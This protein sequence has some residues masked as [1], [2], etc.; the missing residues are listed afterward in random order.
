M[1]RSTFVV[2]SLLF[3]LAACSSGGG[4]ESTSTTAPTTTTAPAPPTF[5]LT[6]LPDAE[7]V[8][9]RPAMTVKVDNADFEGARP[10]TALDQADIVYE[11]LAEGG[12]TRFAAVFQSQVPETVG[13]IRSV[14]GMDP[15]LVTSLGGIVVFSGGTEENVEK[16]A[17]APVN[18]IDENNAG[19]AFFRNDNP[20]RE[21]SLFGRGQALFDFGGEPVP[22]APQFSY[23]PAGTAMVGEPVSAVTVGF[24][25]GGLSGNYA[26]TYT[27][28]AA[29][30]TW[31]R[32]IAGIPFV[33]ADGTQIAPTNVIV[34]MTY[35]PA[36]AEGILAG[37]GDVFVFTQGQLIRGR[38]SRQSIDQPFQ[39]VDA[40]GQPILLTPGTTWVEL[41]P[42]GRPVDV[43]PAALA[44]P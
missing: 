26:S 9:T 20:V 31:K 33:T 5:P 42:S 24:E 14:R 43:V 39:Y 21:H 32:D 11:E 19:D 17:S 2:G 4:D 30:S 7:G 27:W 25:S 41:L 16:I 28:D 37:E 40:A 15:A 10:Q 6:G 13:P 44:A 3:V 1:R 12:V 8:G 23:L 29:T 18:R 34:Q 35:Y 36:E 22:P 38:W